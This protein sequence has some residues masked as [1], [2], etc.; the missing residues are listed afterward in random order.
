MEQSLVLRDIHLPETISWFPPAIGWWLL[1][2]LILLIIFGT[3]WLFKHLTRNTAVKSAH[4]LLA[5]IKA[6]SNTAELEKL[7]KIS[8]W[9]R[10]VSI[11]TTNRDQSAGLTGKAWLSYLDNS[12]QGSPFSQG[13]GQCLIN[14]QFRQAAPDDLD[15][16]GLITLCELWL[17]GQKQ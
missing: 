14:A 3:W 6:D 17:K 16:N 7:R 10:R 1:L 11:S 12:V 9:L 4:K 8:M 5:I 2:L 15:I 13:I